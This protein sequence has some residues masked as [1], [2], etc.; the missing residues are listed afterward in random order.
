MARRPK[1]RFDGE[2]TNLGAF[3]LFQFM[4][5][6]SP[7]Q[8]ATVLARHAAIVRA[9]RPPS[10]CMTASGREI[11][12]RT[13]VVIV[14]ALAALPLTN[15]PTRADGS[16]CANYVKGSTNCGFHSYEQCMA[17]ISGIGGSCQPNPAY[18]AP[19]GTGKRKQP[20][21]S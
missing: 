17:N 18:S 21:N 11:S 20:R 6:R 3:G 14:A 8:S 5:Q 4:A 19:T 16:W 15:G 12:M 9:Y 13:I 10:Q 2:R 1:L 7:E